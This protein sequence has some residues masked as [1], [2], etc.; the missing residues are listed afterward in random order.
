M[1]RF[2]LCIALLCATTAVFSQQFVSTQKQPGDFTISASSMPTIVIDGQDDWLVWKAATLLQSDIES[3]T[4][5]RPML[6]TTLDSAGK[7]SIIIGTV[8]GSSLIK[9]L[10]SQHKVDLSQ[11]T[12][13]WEAFQLRTVAN[14]FPAISNALIISGSD[15]RGTAYGVFE[16]SKQ[17]GVSPW[18]WWAD[19]P[20]TKKTQ[21]FHTEG[22]LQL[23]ITVSQISWHLH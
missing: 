8:S 20:S 4:G 1:K 18:Y 11:F 13:K 19:V 14:A 6:V 16:L 15:K 2:C 23:C 22:C 7:N 5:V 10:A 21:R 12:G 17:L 3:V 9:Q